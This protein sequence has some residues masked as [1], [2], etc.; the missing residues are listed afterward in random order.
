MT[1]PLIDAGME[2]DCAL[3]EL[4]RDTRSPRVAQRVRDAAQQVRDELLALTLGIERKATSIDDVRA[5]LQS[6][7][8]C[9][10]GWLPIAEL[11]RELQGDDG[12]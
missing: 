12:R 3:R 6:A 4:A 7:R 11:V 10:V 8:R 5:V 1:H 2:L 9:G